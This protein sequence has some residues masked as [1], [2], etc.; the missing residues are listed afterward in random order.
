MK[1]VRGTAAS[2]GIR[3]NFGQTLK[4]NFAG[5]SFRKGVAVPIGVSRGGI[6]GRV[7]GGG[8]GQPSRKKSGKRG[9]GWGGWE[10]VG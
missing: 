10:G 8:G 1:S 6:W 4:G 2:E 7:Q 5:G 9:R 3:D